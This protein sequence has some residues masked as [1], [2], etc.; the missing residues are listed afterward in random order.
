M[1]AFTN[2]C[3]SVLKSSRSALQPLPKQR[4]GSLH[5]SQGNRTA[6]QG[7]E[8]CIPLCLQHKHCLCSEAAKFLHLEIICFSRMMMMMMLCI[9]H[10]PNVFLNLLAAVEKGALLL[11]KGQGDGDIGKLINSVLM[12]EI[13]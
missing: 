4:P 6:P 2:D 13:M 10:L 7:T 9:R 11:F 12:G 8:Q 1:D 5:C 3:C